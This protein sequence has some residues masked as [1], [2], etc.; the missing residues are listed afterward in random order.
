MRIRTTKTTNTV[1]YA[2]IKDITKNG[3]RTTCIF[4]NLGTLDKI[5]QRAGNEE[6]LVWLKNYLQEL[7]IKEK[8]NKIPVLIKKDPSKV[9]EKNVQSSFNVGYLF[10]Q[11]IYYK[12]KLDKI[13][14]KIKEQHQF[15]FDLN[16]IL[17]K[18]IYSRIIFP[19]S[20]LKTLELS[21]KFLEQPNFE[22]QHIE[23]ALPVICENMDFIQ[24]ELYKNSNEYMK[25][26][27]KILYYDC[28]NYYFEIEEESGLRQYGKSKENRPNPIVQ[29]GLFM[30][31][32]GIPL[33]FD[34]T[35]G[36]TNEQKTLQPL[37]EKIIKDFEFSEFVVCTDAGLASKANRKFNNKNN[38]KFVTTQSIKK[39][40]S[41]LKN[42]A[43]DLTKGWKLP[44]SNK[45]YNISKLRTDEKLI[46]EYRDKIFYKE[47]WINE[48]GLEQR[49]IVTYSVK[50][51]EYQK[52]IRNNQI[53]RAKKII[54]TNSIKLKKTN[55]NDPKRFIKT[56]NVTKDGEL[57]DKSIYSI[58][59]NIIDEEAKYDG[60]YAVCTN[61]EDS[62]ED[63]IRVNKRRW[64]IEESFR[65]MKTDFK[66]RPI[67]H[68]RDEMIK[69]HF[70]TCFLALIIYRY[71]EKKLD[72]K[73]TAPEIIETLRDMNMKLENECSYIP[74]YIRT[75]LT[76]D[77]HDK[78]GFRTDFEIIS[79]KNIKKILKQTKK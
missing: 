70:I 55:S 68:S 38:R 26:N 23:R 18:L 69:A 16:D 21:K 31:G 54:D 71:V 15:K 41:H 64:E 12:L 63:I 3:K 36:N 17:S 75:D 78:F 74:N 22:Y 48:D 65:I 2:I 45:T 56:L 76:D 59:Q 25:R 13:C 29:M 5:K 77:L 1:Q 24:S 52:K 7:N 19:A 11:N 73:Y 57:A 49:L 53:N 28:T 30:D 14:N 62:V 37:E 60:L 72:E 4:E 61:L 44:G 51:Q 9:I 10:L 42:E 35:P 39:L 43:L 46:E 66:S 6:P 32:N 34:I 67:Y 40:K 47:R 79:E 8:E 50:Y 58:D 27:N 20:K 33:A